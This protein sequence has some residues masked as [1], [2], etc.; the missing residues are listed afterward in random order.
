M[1]PRSSPDASERKEAIASCVHRSNRF[2]SAPVESIAPPD[3]TGSIIWQLDRGLSIS[4]MSRMEVSV[5]SDVIVHRV[6]RADRSDTDNQ[7]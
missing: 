3:R 6:G 5:M 4:T 1:S 7:L 2:R